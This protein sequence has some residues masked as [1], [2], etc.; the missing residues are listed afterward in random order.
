MSWNQFSGSWTALLKTIMS[1]N[2]RVLLGNCAKI[3]VSATHTHITL[4]TWVYWDMMWNIFPTV[5]RCQI[6]FKAT[7]TECSGQYR[8]LLGKQCSAAHRY[9]LILSNGLLK[10]WYSKGCQEHKKAKN[11]CCREK[12]NYGLLFYLHPVQLRWWI[13]RN[14]NCSYHSS[15]KCWISWHQFREADAKTE[16]GVQVAC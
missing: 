15:H 14:S 16:F 2:V 9:N 12:G 11:H 5:G 1:E 8:I 6:I 10:D 3:F 13:R 4:Y 7:I